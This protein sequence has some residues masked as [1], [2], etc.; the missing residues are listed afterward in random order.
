MDDRQVR[1]LLSAVLADAL[2]R[3]HPAR[4]TDP[5]RFSA[6]ALR[7]ELNRTYRRY[8]LRPL[9][10]LI[11]GLAAAST[12]LL[13][14][15]TKADVPPQAV[16][17]RTSPAGNYLA[18][19]FAGSSR[20]MAA[21]AAYY[22]AALRADPRNEDLI[23]RTFLVVLANGAGEEAMALAE[24]LSTIDRNQRVARLALAVRALKRGQNAQAR[25]QL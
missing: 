9:R 14:Y 20:D 4:E 18:A 12:L 6:P 5:S 25:S 13:S 24:R 10:F 19:R 1:G 15:S 23:E 21:A 17:P 3:G 11:A 7:I 16:S 22:R 8:R 2:K